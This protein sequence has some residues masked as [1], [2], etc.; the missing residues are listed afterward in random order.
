MAKKKRTNNVKSNKSR[1]LD[2]INTA[3]AGD[4]CYFLNGNKKILRG[5]I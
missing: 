2:D 5:E 3:K 4:H 1:L